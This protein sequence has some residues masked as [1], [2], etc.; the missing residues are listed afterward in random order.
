MCPSKLDTQHG[1]PAL[2]FSYFQLVTT[3]QR[4]HHFCRM[5]VF[6]NSYWLVVEPTHLKNTLVKLGSSSPNRDEHKKIF[7][8]PPP[9][10]V[11]ACKTSSPPIT[12]TIHGTGINYL[13]NFPIKKNN[14]KCK[15]IYRFRHMDP[16]WDMRFLYTQLGAVRFLEHRNPMDF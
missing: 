9:S 4:C 1:C 16:S 6:N 15:Y 7:E 2:I 3:S 12:K 11:F 13:H 10:L 5:Y 8:L 14:Q